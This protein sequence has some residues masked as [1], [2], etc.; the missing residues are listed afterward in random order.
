MVVAASVD[1]GAAVVVEAGVDCVIGVVA[2]AVCAVE[3]EVDEQP[4]ASA[5]LAE[6]TIRNLWIQPQY[7]RS[8]PE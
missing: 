3:P 1:V 5:A 4:A 6:R 8:A 7:V 2:A